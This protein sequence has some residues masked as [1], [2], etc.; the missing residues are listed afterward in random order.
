MQTT[1]PMKRETVEK[2]LVD[3]LK[4]STQ[5]GVIQGKND[6]YCASTY[7]EHVKRILKDDNKWFTP[8][9]I[10]LGPRSQISVGSQMSVSSAVSIKEAESSVNSVVSTSSILSNCNGMSAEARRCRQHDD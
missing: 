8:S 1:D 5:S 2:Q 10:S 7:V 3:V 6:H 9:E 4:T